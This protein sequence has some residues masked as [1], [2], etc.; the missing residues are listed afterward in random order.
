M[1]GIK[2]KKDDNNK[3]NMV[4]TIKSAHKE[5]KDKERL[6]DAVTDPDL[7]DFAIYEA[8][9]SRI[10]YIYLLKKYKDGVRDKDIDEQLDGK[11]LAINS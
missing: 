9:A 11:N 7:I 1:L 5:W 8:E 3:D 6:L 2:W 10:K 4:D